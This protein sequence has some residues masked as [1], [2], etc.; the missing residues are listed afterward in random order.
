MADQNNLSPGSDETRRSF[1]KGAI[2][3]VVGATLFGAGAFTRIF[4]FFFGPRLTEKAQADLLALRLKRMQSSVQLAEL[5]LERDRDAFILVAP[6]SELN[7]TSGKYFIDFQM[8]AALAFLDAKGLPNLL[9]AKCTHLGCTVGNQVDEKGQILCPCHISYFNIETG[10]PNL[11]A[12]AKLPL[13]HLPWVLMDKNKKTIARQ[14]AHGQII[15]AT[16]EA[17]LK[18][19]YVYLA[20]TT[21]GSPA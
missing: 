14:D 12:P 1:V 2:G 21:Q 3:L 17:A 15:G 4:E 6:L 10:Q 19:A 8:R 5:E 20:K 9:S 18:D 11:G 13:E 7:A 16:T